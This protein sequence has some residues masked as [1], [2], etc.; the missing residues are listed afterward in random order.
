M[1]KSG[2][3]VFKRYEQNKIELL[4][5]SYEE[6]IPKGHLVRLVNTGIE[7]MN[8]EGLIN[9]YKGGGTS[10]FH[11]K[12]LV[13]V[14]VYSY[15]QRIYSS[16][17][18]AKAL[19]E[20][21]YFHWLSGNNEP[22]FRTINRFRS[23][24]LKQQI[25]QVFASMIKILHDLGYVSLDNYF[26]DGTKIEAN[27]NKYSFVW[28]KTVGKQKEKLEQKIIK[29]ILDH[30]DKINEEEEKKYGDKDL[31]E[32]GEGIRID[33]NLLEE[34]IKELNEK[35]EEIANDPER[36][37]REE[38]KELERKKKKIE[39]DYLER[40]KRYEDQG[41]LFKGRNSFS[42]TD[43]DA[44]FMRMKE[45]Q[46]R[47]GQL[48]A[49]YNVQ[50]GT[51][52]Q[53]ILG[54]TI[55][56]RP[57]DTGTL[58][59]H[60]EEIKRNLGITPKRIITDAGYGSQENYEYLETQEIEAYVKYNMFDKEQ[61]K[62]YKPDPFKA[63]NM[64]YNELKDEFICADNRVLVYTHQE[65]YKT[66]NGYKRDKRV[67]KSKDCTGCKLKDSCNKEAKNKM[68]SVSHDLVRYRKQAKERLESPEG[69]QLSS[70]RFR[71][72]EPVFG[73]IKYNRG[74]KRFTLRGSGKVHLE[75]GLHSLA[76]NFMKLHTHQNSNNLRPS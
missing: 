54:Y 41:E 26:L 76:H 48:K 15:T 25:D 33:S 57:G 2:K 58:I 45:D 4:P 56:Q 50:I 34:K 43:T 65:S 7:Q 74:F 16:R 52:N 1:G 23:S 75:F 59:P 18:I 49:A 44:T 39:K 63:E 42:K 29:E 64:Q 61:K 38:E 28:K 12:M 5:A 30:A 32:M 66:E 69:R 55:H 37:R 10:S 6:L 68:I 62:N 71:D 14:I 46:M 22:D 31:E 67:Y 70:Q 51:E 8:L 9:E 53:F 60:M 73:Q 21:L 35:L 27:A 20:N 36:K 47:N 24:R 17:Q 3:V 72:T 19:R 11:P 13:K 40:L